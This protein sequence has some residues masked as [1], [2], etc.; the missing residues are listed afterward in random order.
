[1]SS[2]QD[3][4]VLLPQHKDLIQAFSKQSLAAL[5]TDPMEAE[6]QSWTAP[7]RS[8]ALDHYLKMGWSYGLFAGEE[9]LVGYLLAQPYLFHRGLTQTLWVEHVEA[10]SM[11]QKT[12]LIETAYRWARDKH[13]Q[14]V[15]IHGSRDLFE[16]L[17]PL[18]HWK[19]C[20]QVDSCLI[21]I[22]SAKF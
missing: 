11:E 21:E 20:R 3:V 16:S 18:N 2:S 15:L 4:R 13:F 1:M 6:M 17:S 10:S 14:C 9:R 7:W 19:H 12:A 22:R 8:E 5:V